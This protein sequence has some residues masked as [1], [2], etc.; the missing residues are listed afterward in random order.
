M[1]ALICAFARSPFHFAKKG[2]LATVRP[3]TLAAQ[4]VTTPLQRTDIDRWPGVRRSVLA[5][6]CIG[7]GKGT[8]TGL[9][10]P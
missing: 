2:R 6:Q 9:E 8:A 4:V 1:N 7:G 10:R 5:A 3:D